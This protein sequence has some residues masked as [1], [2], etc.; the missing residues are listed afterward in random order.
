MYRTP[1]LIRAGIIALFVPALSGCSLM[2]YMERPD[3]S[4]I[5]SAGAAETTAEALA[6][7]NTAEETTEEELNVSRE[8]AAAVD[9]VEK[10]YLIM[11]EIRV[12]YEQALDAMDQFVCEVTV[13]EEAEPI[14]EQALE[15]LRDKQEEW[16]EFTVDEAVSDAL[17]TYGI[18]VEEYTEL[19]NRQKE[20]LDEY[21]QA[22]QIMQ[23]HLIAAEE[24]EEAF[25]KADFC[26]MIYREKQ[27]GQ[28]GY[29]YYHYLNRWFIN[30]DEQEK[31]HLQER[32]IERME[33]CAPRYSFW[34]ERP[35]EAEA[36]AQVF[37]GEVQGFGKLS[38]E[39][40]GEKTMSYDVAGQEFGQLFDK[41]EQRW[42]EEKGLS[43]G[44]Q[45]ESATFDEENGQENAEK[46]EE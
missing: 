45:E 40:L 21:I 12:P 10:L 34:Y 42:E 4:T 28:Y 37:L 2:N 22:V 19:G 39:Y 3:S 24:S 13:R 33:W 27:F 16:P 15:I 1:K 38:Q 26:Y 18:S 23:E 17:N 32:L 43:E 29:E 31:E 11:D 8:F 36:K 5:A 6:E 25:G 14:L 41:V 20:D 35:E 7:E 30:A 9:G 46:T 44:A